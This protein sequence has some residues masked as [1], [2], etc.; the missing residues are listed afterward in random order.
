MV[1]F[2]ATPNKFNGP[3]AKAVKETSKKRVSPNYGGIKKPRR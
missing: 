1:R 2:K 3:L